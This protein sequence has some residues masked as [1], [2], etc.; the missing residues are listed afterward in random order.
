MIVNGI[1]LKR[2][3][4]AILFVAE[5]PVS[6]ATL[7]RIIPEADSISIKEALYELKKDYSKGFSFHLVEVAEGFQFR[8]KIEFGM[9]IRRLKRGIRPPLGRAALETLAIIAYKQPITRAEIERLRG[10]DV[11]GILKYLLERELIRILG[12]REVPGRPLVYGTTRRFLALFNLK[13][14]KELPK[15]EGLD[16]PEEISLK[17]QKQIEIPLKEEN[18]DKKRETD[19]TTSE[20]NS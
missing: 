6:L 11:S 7:I 14:L 15:I 4:E 8:T 16:L 18:N 3:I 17:R 9:W 10:V 19:R 20:N 13:S 2:I 12:R 1:E 5:E